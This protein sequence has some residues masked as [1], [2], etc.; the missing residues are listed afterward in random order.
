MAK[1]GFESKYSGS[2]TGSLPTVYGSQPYF[3]QFTQPVLKET[4]LNS[5]SIL[6]SNSYL[7]WRKNYNP[8]WRF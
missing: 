4:P 2:Q 6:F 7:L 1:Q 8:E 5:E 3:W